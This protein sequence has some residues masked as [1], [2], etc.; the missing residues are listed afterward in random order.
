MWKSTGGPGELPGESIGAV[1]E[2]RVFA[3]PGD[4]V[5]IGRPFEGARTVLGSHG[6]VAGEGELL[7]SVNPPAYMYYEKE[8]SK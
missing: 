6:C 8:K 3:V 5:V 4:A 2:I 7:K 1:Q